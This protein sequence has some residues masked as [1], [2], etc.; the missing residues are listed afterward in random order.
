VAKRSEADKLIA[1][2]LFMG[3]VSFFLSRAA[4]RG[5]GPAAAAKPLQPVSH[6]LDLTGLSPTARLVALGAAAALLSR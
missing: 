4:V 3:V 5:A 6:G 1:P 2:I